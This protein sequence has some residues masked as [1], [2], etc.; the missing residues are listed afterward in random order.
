MPRLIGSRWAVKVTGTVWP[1]DPTSLDPV[2]ERHVR[3]AAGR[4]YYDVAPFR[5]IY[6]GHAGQSLDVE[7]ELVR[8]A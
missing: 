5:G 4:D 7:V 6:A 2:A 3:V 1:L 8:R